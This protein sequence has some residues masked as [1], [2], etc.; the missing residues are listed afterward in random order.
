[1]ALS[2]ATNALSLRSGDAQL[3]QA[4]RIAVGDLLGNVQPFKDG[5]LD[6]PAPCLIAGLEYVTPWTRDAAFNTWFALSRLAPGVARDTLLAVLERTD[7]GTVR[8]G[9]QYWDAI[10]WAQGAWE[11][12]GVTNDRTF[13]A[14]AFE[15]VSNSLTRFEAEEFDSADGLFRGGACFQDGV[16]GYP[17][18]YAPQA[19]DP[20][21]SGIH[22]WVEVAKIKRFPTGGGMPCKAL[23][24][25]CLYYRAYRV[26][27][28]MADALGV[29][30]N[31]SWEGKAQALRTAINTRF[32]SDELGRYRY[33]VDA[34]GND[35]RQEGLGHAFA[36][37]FGVADEAQARRVFETIHLSAHGIPCVWPT[38]SR[39]AERG[40]YGRHSGPIWPQVNAAW[41]LACVARGREDLARRELVSLAAKACRDG[42]FIE[43]FHP[44]T[45]QPYGGLQE[46]HERA[47]MEIYP[48][49]QRQSWCAS[50]YL[51]MVAALKL[52]SL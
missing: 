47:G 16:A 14:L 26:A 15:A 3:D 19:G 37:L 51:A 31:A 45:G 50:G 25:N 1:M 34:P 13:L 7:D 30:P 20:P 8:I 28:L 43:V 12:Y 9:G 21:F 2:F 40:E 41:A 48:V 46:H 33:L 18:Y 6:A 52:P 38:Y 10:I 23:S 44:D 5:L 49:L 39:Y 4:F 32:W 36:L 17:D 24:T 42:G 11:H 22:V 27:L 29:A 35:D